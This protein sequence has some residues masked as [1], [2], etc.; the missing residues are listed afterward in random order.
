[1]SVHQFIRHR[2]GWVGLIAV[3][4]LCVPMAAFGANDLPNQDQNAD[5]GE[6]TISVNVG[7]VVLPVTVTDRRGDAVSG[8]RANDFHLYDDGHLRPITLFEPEDVPATIGL[9]VDNSGSMLG[10]R[11]EV[12]AAGLAFARSSNPLDQMFVVN[13]NQEASL[14]LPHGIPFTSNVQQLD[15][16]LSENA[17]AGNTALYDGIAAA[18]QHI[19]TGTRERKAL[20]VVSDGGDNS[21]QISLSD[22]LK[23]VAASNVVI[24]TIGLFDQ[25]YPYENPRVL[26]RLAEMT[27]GTAYFPQSVSDVTAICQDI[28]QDIRHQYTIG[29]SPTEAAADTYHTIRV[30]ARVTGKRGLRVR[31][32]AGYFISHAEAPETL[33]GALSK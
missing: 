19:K 17:A 18:L 4:A 12:I 29:Y 15:G 2:A 23:R 26:K 25:G 9:V 13:F 32:R 14:G 20:I 6:Y 27:G 16:A 28:A 10:K 11:A 21:S 31:T 7:L 1:M 30:T 22:L 8:L 5:P 24:D 33:V 3:L